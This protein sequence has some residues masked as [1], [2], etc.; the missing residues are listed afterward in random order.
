MMYKLFFVNLVNIGSELDLILIRAGKRD[1]K[2]NDITVRIYH[3]L[4][5]TGR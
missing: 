4:F 3:R 1:H 5:G 2:L